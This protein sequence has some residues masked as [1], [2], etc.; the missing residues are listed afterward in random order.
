MEPFPLNNTVPSRLPLPERPE[1]TY[2]NI[3]GSRP[4]NE[5]PS[6]PST[7]PVKEPVSFADLDRAEFME[8]AGSNKIYLLELLGA[9]MLII[10]YDAA[11]AQA[12]YARI[13]GVKGDPIEL[14]EATAIRNQ[15]DVQYDTLKHVVSALQSA[16]K[17]ERVGLYSNKE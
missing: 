12:N 13:K 7:Q 10:G 16:L 1:P 4:L 3:S 6:I 2:V 5:V 15:L 9:E 14:A 8:L 11:L 17:V